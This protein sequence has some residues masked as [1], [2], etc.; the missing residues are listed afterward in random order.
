[1]ESTK[2]MDK[3]EAQFIN[4]ARRYVETLSSLAECCSECF[5]LLCCFIT[6]FL[7]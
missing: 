3:R 7:W 5:N 2:F 4:D 6:R 1:M